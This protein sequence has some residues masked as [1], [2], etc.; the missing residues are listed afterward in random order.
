[1][2]ATQNAQR[3]IE[4]SGTP[5]SLLHSRKIPHLY[6]MERINYVFYQIVSIVF[7]PL[8]IIPYLLMLMA[9]INPYDFSAFQGPEK[10]MLF[11][12]VVISTVILPS[13]AIVMMYSL[14][15][16][17]SV[18]LNNSKERM[19]PFIAA[20]VFYLWLFANFLYNPTIPKLFNVILFASIIGLF[21]S[22]VINLFIKLSIHCLGMGSL[23]TSVG[24]IFY[25]WS[26]LYSRQIN[27]TDKSMIYLVVLTILAAGLVG[28]ARLH[29]KVHNLPEVYMGYFIGLIS[30]LIAYFSIELIFYG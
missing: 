30:P 15:L 2:K 12:Q 11:F 28:T 6:G 18:E 5:N 27:W 23:I 17:S 19:F 25:E 10:H 26:M 21:L 1:M 4:N 22:M 24:L 7:H 20:A 9:A 8:L 29:L 14:G 13:L 16:V 3:V